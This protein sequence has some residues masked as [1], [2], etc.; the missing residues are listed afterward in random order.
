MINEAVNTHMEHVSDLIFNEG[1]DG[2]R[3]AINSLRE[4]RNTLRGAVSNT[5]ISTKIDGAPAI[6]VGIDPEDGIFFVAKKG[7]F[8]KNPKLYKTQKDIDEDLN[9]EL[10]ELFSLLL[11]V[12]KKLGIKSGVYQG[13][14]LFTQKSL[15]NH[16]IEGT[17][18]V[19]FHPNTIVYAVPVESDIATK[20]NRAK[21]GIAFHTVYSG[22]TIQSLSASFGEKIVDR[23][24]NTADIWAI[25]AAYSNDTGRATLTTDESKKIDL[26]LS[27]I[28]R[29]F[30]KTSADLI[31]TIS[32]NEEL[33]GLTKIYI[34]SLIKT[35]KTGLN[36]KQMTLGL[37]KFIIDRFEKEIAEKKTARGKETS[38]KKRE[39]ILVFFKNFSTSNI[40]NLFELFNRLE[41]AK[42]M[43]VGVLSRAS[44]TSH[45]VKTSSGFKATTPEGFVAIDIDGNA[46]KFVDRLEFS[47]NNFSSEIIK[48]WQK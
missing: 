18:Y 33:L 41:E 8:N 43:L 29:L 2:T 12:L 3:K 48:G 21:V 10:H 25:D 31:N 17:D 7:I 14:L 13:D 24:A 44:R 38:E 9:G 6:F 34:N 47:K 35:N 4:I 16:E 46:V 45:F 15:R 40:A 26:I 28:G 37:Y 32:R 39:Q 23:F 22:N 36:G 11:G 20:I 19:T 27:S 5:K 1:V 42:K 30:N